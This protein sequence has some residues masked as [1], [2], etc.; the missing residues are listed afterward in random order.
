MVKE[1]AGTEGKK[2]NAEKA[3][4][5]L[6]LVC[7][8]TAHC[9]FGCSLNSVLMLKKY[10]CNQRQQE[11]CVKH[12]KSC[13]YT[14]DTRYSRQ[15]DCLDISLISLQF[16][17]PLIKQWPTPP[18]P[19]LMRFVVKL[20][21]QTSLWSTPVRV[22]YVPKPWDPFPSEQGSSIMQHLCQLPDNTKDLQM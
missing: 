18:F 12:I 1:G 21:S 4:L 3:N 22:Q 8:V 11:L 10:L 16:A 5:F 20:D 13:I 14:L 7:R 15:A 2:Q 19:K 9:S 17:H 6:C